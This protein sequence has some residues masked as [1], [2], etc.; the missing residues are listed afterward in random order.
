MA[1]KTV[2]LVHRDRNARNRSPFSGAAGERRIAFTIVNGKAEVAVDAN[3]FPQPRAG[4]ALLWVAI[5]YDAA[6]GATRY[7]A[8]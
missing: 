1:A 8:R 2:K 3:W 6:S 7:R 5:S 4:I